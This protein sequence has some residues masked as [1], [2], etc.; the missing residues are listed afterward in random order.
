M[1][2]N[3]IHDLLE[4]AGSS[5][6]GQPRLIEPVSSS[7]AGQPRSVHFIFIPILFHSI[8][9]RGLVGYINLVASFISFQ[10]VFLTM[11]RDFQLKQ[12]FNQFDEDQDGKLSPSELRRCV[13]LI[14]GELPLEEAE[15][16]VQTLDSDGDG[17]LS[18]EDFVKLME[19]EGEGEEEKMKELREAF[20]MYD[21]DGCGYI[22]A[23]SLKR[24]LSRLGEKKSVDECKVMINQFDLN[25]DGVLSFDEFKVMML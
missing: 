21:I 7:M 23:K 24:M 14:G 17:L 22:T 11:K 6:A 18:L 12:V 15:A 4:P 8:E 5:M 3:R 10:I 2:V 19:G 1:I 13:R 25:G 9:K 20:K 16:V